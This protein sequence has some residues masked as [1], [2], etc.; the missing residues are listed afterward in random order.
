MFCS[1]IL[2]SNNP[3]NPYQIKWRLIYGFIFVSSKKFHFKKSA[4][5][6]NGA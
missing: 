6:E 1:D 2:I 4:R 5:F 3:C